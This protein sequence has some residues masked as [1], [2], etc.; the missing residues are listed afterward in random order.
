MTFPIS[1]PFGLSSASQRRLGTL[2]PRGIPPLSPYTNGTGR[3]DTRRR[4]CA[5][6]DRRP[7]PAAGAGTKLEEIRRVAGRSCVTH[8]R[9]GATRRPHAGNVRL[10]THQIVQS[11]M[12]DCLPRTS[13]S[14]TWTRSLGGR[15][16]AWRVE[17]AM[18]T[19]CLVVFVMPSMR[20]AVFT[21]SP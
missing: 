2:E 4:E 17:S 20:D 16:R 7:S 3:I 15:R 14:P 10:R 8:D 11:L 19:D 6:E 5:A 18:R 1:C 13:N 9:E 12:L 21:V